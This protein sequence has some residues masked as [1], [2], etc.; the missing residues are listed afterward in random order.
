M[1][2]KFILFLFLIL[3]SCV[4]QRKINGVYVLTKKNNSYNI[5]LK[6]ENNKRYELQTV[7]TIG[8]GI[9]RGVWIEENNKIKLFPNK[10]IIDKVFIDDT[11]VERQEFRPF[12]DTIIMKIKGSKI[13]RIN[14]KG[15]ISKNF[16]LK[17]L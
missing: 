15:I 12:S 16:C 3:C 13:Y 10:P 17:K 5:I 11:I 2:N 6:L 7:S 14:D 9:T 8:G 4:S 1:K